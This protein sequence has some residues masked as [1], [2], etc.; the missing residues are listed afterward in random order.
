[1]AG[2]ALG[3]ANR[4]RADLANAQIRTP[5][6]FI[7]PI[8]SWASEPNQEICVQLVM[9]PPARGMVWAVIQEASSEAR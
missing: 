2:R 8:R 1:M 5:R 9:E 6:A 3:S 7:S 4:H